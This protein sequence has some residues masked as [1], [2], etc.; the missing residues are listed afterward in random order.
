MRHIGALLACAAV[1]AAGA[2]AADDQ[3]AWTAGISNPSGV[4]YIVEAIVEGDGV[5]Y[6]GGGFS[7]A[8]GVDTP[9]AAAFDGVDWR[10][11][12]DPA[13]GPDA[14]VLTLLY[15]G[16]DLYAG[17]MFLFAEGLNASRVAR[18][19][20]Q[21]WHAVGSLAAGDAVTALE[22]HDNGS[23]PALY[24][25][26]RRDFG[27]SDHESFLVRLGPGDVWEPVGGTPQDPTLFT[28][29]VNDLQSAQDGTGR[30]YAAGH[31][32]MVGDVEINSFAAWN[33]EQWQPVGGQGLWNDYTDDWGDV[34]QVPGLVHALQYARFQGGGEA[35]FVLGDFEHAGDESIEHIAAWVDESWEPSPPLDATRYIAAATWNGDLLAAVSYHDQVDDPQIN[36]VMRLENGQQ[37]VPESDD[38]YSADIPGGALYKT[39]LAGAERLFYGGEWLDGYSSYSGGIQQYV[40]DRWFGLGGDEASLG[41]HNTARTLAVYRDGDRQRLYV[42]GTLAR[43]DATHSYRGLLC[44]DGASYSYLDGASVSDAR[45]MIVYDEGFGPRLYVASSGSITTPGGFATRHVAAWD[46]A[47][48][49]ALGEGPSAGWRGAYDLQSFDDG[50]GFD[51]YVGGD[52]LFAMWDGSAWSVPG[53]GVTGSVHALAVGQLHGNSVLFVGGDITRAGL[54]FPQNIAAWD[55]E[56]WHEVGAGLPGKV[57]SLAWYGG[58]LYAAGEFGDDPLHVWDGQEWRAITKVLGTDPVVHRLRVIDGTLYVMGHVHYSDPY[59]GVLLYDGEEWTGIPNAPNDVHDAAFYDDGA[60]EPALYIGGEFFEA[61]GVTSR[62]IARYGLSLPEPVFADLNNDGAVDQGDLGLL[63]AAFGRGPGEPFFDVRADLNRDFLINQPDLAE[64]LANYEQKRRSD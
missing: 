2:A 14:P 11:L 46:G 12:G 63:L 50:D 51:L 25:A 64:V 9:F 19:D 22:L 62:K 57:T 61:G 38:P 33:G 29:E 13:A 1:V 20:G 43:S 58:K 40:H 36:L 49:H 59:F 17:G 21:A 3:P 56:D 35:L 5:I 55:G 16:A 15:D 53:L 34:V 31:F 28:G 37:W 39:H 41:Y 60:G 6:V 45:D 8:G 18:W 4:N 7:Q 42:G 10:P 48:W 54:I 23:G 24:A 26:V 44:W 30:L 52:S 27:Y 47:Q 32:G